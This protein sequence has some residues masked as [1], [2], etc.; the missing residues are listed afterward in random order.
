MNKG[1][2]VHSPPIPKNRLV[3][4]FDNKELSLGADA[5]WWNFFGK[6]FEHKYK[7]W[8]K[9]VFLNKMK[10]TFNFDRMGWGV[11]RLCAPFAVDN[12]GAITPLLM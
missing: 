3:S 2:K 7:K 9:K 4:W 5:I 11:D 10:G 8:K 6:K 1:F 12:L